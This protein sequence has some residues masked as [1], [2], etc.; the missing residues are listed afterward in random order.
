MTAAK[1]VCGGFA[2]IKASVLSVGPS[3][4]NAAARS[5]LSLSRQH[6]YGRASRSASTLCSR[7]ARSTREYAG[8]SC[9]FALVTHCLG[10]PRGYPREKCL[11]APTAQSPCWRLERR[12]VPCTP[13]SDAALATRFRARAEERVCIAA[14]LSVVRRGGGRLRTEP[15]A[16]SEANLQRGPPPTSAA[17]QSSPY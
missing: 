7:K 9:L 1:S 16:W 11:E 15:G 13:T 2:R 14:L 6:P 3:S 8:S 17:K 4:T 10:I 5:G 12:V